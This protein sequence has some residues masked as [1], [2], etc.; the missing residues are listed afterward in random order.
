MQVHAGAD[1]DSLSYID[2]KT[3]VRK[4]N[5]Y[6]PDDPIKDLRRSK[7]DPIADLRRAHE[8]AHDVGSDCSSTDTKPD[9][10]DVK[11]RSDRGIRFSRAKLG[12]DEDDSSCDASSQSSSVQVSP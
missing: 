4:Y 8:I 10:D 3:A 6:H 1:L 7:K 12:N 5:L 2:V 9:L 11:S